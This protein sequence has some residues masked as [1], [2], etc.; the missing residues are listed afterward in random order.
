MKKNNN[1]TNHTD[2]DHNPCC[3][4][5]TKCTCSPKKEPKEKTNK[6][7]KW[8]V[9]D[10]FVVIIILVF[11]LLD[12]QYELSGL[13]WLAL[14]TF[15]LFLIP[16]A[17]FILNCFSFVLILLLSSSA[18]SQVLIDKDEYEYL[19]YNKQHNQETE[20]PAIPDRPADASD[21]SINFG[22]GLSGEIIGGGVAY[23]KQFYDGLF[24]VGEFAAHQNLGP[25]KMKKFPNLRHTF[26]SVAVGPR[27]EIPFDYGLTPFI[28][29]SVGPTYQKSNGLT[30][31]YHAECGFGYT[32]SA[33]FV[34]SFWPTINVASISFEVKGRTIA[35]FL[36]L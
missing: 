3:Y 10:F 4:P 19:K 25:E 11:G 8:A 9:L 35:N 36:G 26:L 30:I 15:V 16:V 14:A 6:F 29:L 23:Q 33:F 22:G 31:A 28:Q 24:V 34:F 12:G 17:R 13:L 18:F 5:G 32:D 27:I 21:F 7:P 1:G 2:M 20:T